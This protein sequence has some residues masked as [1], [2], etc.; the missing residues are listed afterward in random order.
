MVRR[1]APA[2]HDAL[3][4]VDLEILFEVYVA[5][6]RVEAILPDS[7]VACIA[8]RKIIASF[9]RDMSASPNFSSASH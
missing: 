8:A 5:A 6:L 3:S 9:R 4:P 7:D 2:S 1:V